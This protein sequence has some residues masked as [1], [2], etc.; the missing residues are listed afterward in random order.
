MNKKPHVI[1]DDVF[2]N[3][4]NTGIAR[5]WRSILQELNDDPSIY[6]DHFQLSIINRSDALSGLNFKK[7]NFPQYDSWLPSADRRLLTALCQQESVDLFVSSYYTFPV[8]IPNLMPVYDLIPEKQHFEFES[9]AWIERIL[10]FSNAQKYFAISESTKRDLVQHYPFIESSDV[11]VSHPGIDHNVFNSN[12]SAGKNHFQLPSEF[13]NYYVM[14]GTRGGYKNF[15]IVLRT[16]ADGGFNDSSIVVVGGEALSDSEIEVA[17]KAGIPLA[18][19]VLS[20]YELVQCLRGAVALIYPSLY[21]GFGLPPAECLA[22]GT[23]VIVGNNSSLPEV[24][25]DCGLFLSSNSSQALIEAMKKAQSPEWRAHVKENGPKQVSKFTWKKMACDFVDAVNES[26]GNPPNSNLVAVS[27][28]M[29]N[30]D[31]LMS[32][33]QA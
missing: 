6:S 28:L 19:Y 23:P 33:I 12:S 22:V 2:F 17:N 13:E 3:I 11:R 14:L 30:Y 15:D 29:K 18:R 24:V 10:G 4:N 1:F 9:R 21:E 5:V 8:A 27:E 20:D 31:S 26:L 16:I 25:G 32:L 7:Y